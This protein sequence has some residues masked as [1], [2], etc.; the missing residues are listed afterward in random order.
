MCHTALNL[1]DA[2]AIPPP[3]IHVSFWCL[4]YGM[5]IF[6]DNNCFCTLLVPGVLHSQSS[7]SDADG[8]NF[9]NHFPNTKLFLWLWL[10]GCMRE[11]SILFSYCLLNLKIAISVLY[12]CSFII[13]FLC[14][15][16]VHTRFLNDDVLYKR[17]WFNIY[18]QKKNQSRHCSKRFIFPKNIFPFF[19]E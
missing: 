6:D 3:F 18:T 9:E 2:I 17:T 12:S 13:L 1:G 8:R 10:C 16:N 4:N 14:V 19:F 11:V 15:S 5:R 7:I